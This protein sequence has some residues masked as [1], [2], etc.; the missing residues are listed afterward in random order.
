[1]SAAQ[2]QSVSSGDIATRY[3]EDGYA[4]PVDI[5]SAEEA[6]AYR[7]QLEVL[8]KR[9]EGTR[10]GNKG[11]LNFTHTVF[12]FADEIARNPKILDIVETILGP[13][14][15][16]W[17]STFFLKEPR[18]E[19]YVS[20]HQDLRYWGLDDPEGQ[21][22]VW[23]A[24]GPVYRENG[25]MRF[26]PGSHKHPIV[27]HK[28]SFDDANF[29]T[30]GQEADIDIDEDTVVHCELEPGQVSLH[31]GKLLH[32]SAPNRSDERRVG[33]VINYVAPHV[34]QVVASRDYAMLVRGEDRF[35]NFLPVPPPE[36]DLS[37]DA[38]AWHQ[39][40]LDAQ[41]ETLYDGAEDAA[42]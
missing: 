15:L 25:C 37:K 30:R 28:D 6:A 34:K 29:L 32:A 14:L 13:D 5:F 18:T 40:I 39:R 17:G 42:R 10:I 12:R 33:F 20:W 23:L 9:V 8:E 26:V 22:S 16:V 36:E 11:Q 7:A 38:L 41:N 31:H 27:E 19:S 4:F 3:A 2:A 21:V 35:G 24:L 1:M